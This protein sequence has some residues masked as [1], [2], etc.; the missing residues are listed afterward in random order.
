MTERQAEAVVAAL[1]AWLDARGP[2]ERGNLVRALMGKAAR[3]SAE[4]SVVADPD[5]YVLG[6]DFL[7]DPLGPKE[8]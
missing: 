7:T 5:P 4:P 3:L 6:S 8:Y 2:V 1:D